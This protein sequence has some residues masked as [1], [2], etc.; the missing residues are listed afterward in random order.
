M[1]DTLW[2]LVCSDKQPALMFKVERT[3]CQ[4]KDFMMSSGYKELI[5]SQHFQWQ[6]RTSELCYHSQRLPLSY[7]SG[8]FP[9][10]LPL[11]PFCVTPPP[12]LWPWLCQKLVRCLL[13][14]LTPYYCEMHFLVS[15]LLSK[16][17]SVTQWGSNSLGKK[18][19]LA[20]V[21]SLCFFG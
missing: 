4:G 20:E 13:Q 5:Q 12:A 3:R 17:R 21:K 10:S 1:A 2:I 11:P 14:V 8:P 15:F 19:G 18:T 9:L 16:Q 7:D 6:L